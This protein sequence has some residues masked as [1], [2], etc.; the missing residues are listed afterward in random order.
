MSH[1]YYTLFFL[2]LWMFG[3]LFVFWQAP[4]KNRDPYHWIFWATLLGPLVAIVFLSL[5][6][7]RTT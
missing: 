6:A 7:R 5:P 3:P 1:H 2:L 4:R